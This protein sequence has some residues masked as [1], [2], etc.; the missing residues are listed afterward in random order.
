[1]YFDPGQGLASIDGVSKNVLLARRST[2]VLV[3]NGLKQAGMP[4]PKILEAYNVEKTTLAVLAA[5]GNG[6]GTLIGN[7][8]EDTVKALGGTIMRWEPVQDA[9]SFH[10]RMHVC[11]P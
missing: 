7:L 5:G 6:W 2:G 1:V 8:L 3:A 9:G 4:K 11:Y 10:L